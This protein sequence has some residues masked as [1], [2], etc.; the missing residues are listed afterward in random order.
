MTRPV[1]AVDGRYGLRSPRRGVGEYV[2]Q[3]LVHL[4][5]LSN[6]PYDIEVFGDVSADPEV[7]ERL[8]L[9][10]PVHIPLAPN[11]FMWEQ[12]AFPQAASRASLIH[13]TANIGPLTT[14]KPLAL[15]IHDVIEWHRGKDFPSDI[16]LRHH[17]SRFYRM[18]ALKKLSK[19][20]RTVFTVSE[21]AK[22]DISRTLGLPAEK[23]RVT[24]LATKIAAEEPHFPKDPYFLALGALDPRKNLKGILIAM[25]EVE[26]PVTLKVV[27]IEPRALNGFRSLVRDW[28]L[29][30]RVTLQGM[31][32]DDELKALYQ[33][34][35]GFIYLSFYEG[36]G[37]PVLEAMASGCPVIGS[38]TTS[39]P[40]V[41]G[42][43][44][45]AVSVHNP[46]EL[47]SVMERLYRDGEWQRSLSRSGLERAQTFHWRKTAELTHQ[48]YLDALSLTP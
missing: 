17:I 26:S 12:M 2:Y 13:G 47:I 43:A 22:R 10:Y 44:G 41:M 29:S 19:K 38:D 31:V 32:S 4:R 15:T 7:V 25:R 45:V 39:I 14:R 48:G 27:G 21:H 37:L 11:F 46:N 30:D 6:R 28:G 20:A 36:F 24:P 8:Q 3:L 16:P 1:I 40:E 5:Y 23:I 33:H 34:A 9:L 35:T 18:N 42:G